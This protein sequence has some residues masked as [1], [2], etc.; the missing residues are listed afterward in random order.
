M[1]LDVFSLRGKT[2]L[3]TG[4]TSEIGFAIARALYKA[5]ASIAI[6][7]RN[8][9][10]A[11]KGLQDYRTEEIPVRAF[12]CD[13]TRPEQVSLMDERLR[14]YGMDIDILVNNA[15]II[16]R[17]PVSETS[18]NDF[19]QVLE[20]DLT[21]PFIVSKAFLPAMERRGSG[22]II[23]I[24]SVTST[25]AREN[26]S[27]YASAKAGLA[28]LTQSICAE[29]ASKGIQC[30]AIAPGY[31]ATSQTTPLRTPDSRGNEN[32]FDTFIKK[33][34]PAGRWGRAEDL[35]GAAIFLASSASDFVN[36]Q[37][38]YIDGGLTSYLG[39]S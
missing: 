14:A 32:P 17:T 39:K 28:M 21:A 13:V 10:K 23:N 29:Y 4:G 12:L 1:Y 9:L 26:V 5:G 6:C 38:L 25:L 31:I 15:G 20:T 34:T 11:V 37:T 30:N 36:G 8:A 22:K 35:A 18:V 33:R 3:I 24:C 19:R 27:A 2:A 16:K 7:A